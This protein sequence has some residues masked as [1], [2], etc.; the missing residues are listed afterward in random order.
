MAK[1]TRPITPWFSGR[2]KTMREAKGMTQPALA[3]AAGC[4]AI[5]IAKLEG[6][7][8]EPSLWLVLALCDALACT[9][10]EL[11][12]KTRQ[13]YKPAGDGPVSDA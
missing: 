1:R 4:H 2:L 13:P 7:T 11:A 6:G 10:D 3:E 12:G 8:Q 5:T 9:F